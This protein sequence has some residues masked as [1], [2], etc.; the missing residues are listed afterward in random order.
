MSLHRKKSKKLSRDCNLSDIKLYIS[1]AT[2]I[3]LAL[4]LHETKK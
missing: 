3:A 1:V 2:S 4:P